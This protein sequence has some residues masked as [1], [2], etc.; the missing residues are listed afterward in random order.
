MAEKTLGIYVM[1]Y[2]RSNLITTMHLFEECTYVVRKSEENE[3]LAAGVANVWAV[4]DSLIDSGQ[5][6]YWH[7]IRNAPED[8]VFVADDDIEDIIYRLN[9]TTRLEKNKEIITSEV[10]RIAQ[11]LVDLNLG[12]AC[13]DSTGIPY[14]YDG[15]FAFK[16]TSGSMK[17]VYKEAFKATFDPDVPYNYDLDIVLQELL[18]NRIIIKPR[19]IV[20]KDK[21][22]VNA[23]G[24]Q[25]QKT[26][27]KRKDS[28]SNMH[29]KW[30]SYFGYSIKNNRPRIRVVR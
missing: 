11:I 19:Y 17:W 8:V 25:E 30:G 9:D 28:I 16:G 27:S 13:N 4:E 10:E 5:K 29:R 3:Y 15:E 20:G 18:R 24:D 26:A 2:K 12:Y 7:I 1:S 23:G 6:V 21:G 22:D 14:G